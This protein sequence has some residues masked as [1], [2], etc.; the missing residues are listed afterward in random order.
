MIDFEKLDKHK[1]Y[2]GLQYGTSLI[3]KQIRRFSKDYAPDSKEIPTHVLAF[4]YRLGEWWIYESH[5]DGNK[6]LGVPAGVRRYKLS[7]WLEIEKNTQNQFKAVPFDFDFKTLEHYIGQ[8]YGVGDIRSL[9]KA[10]IFH[11]N[12]KQ[13]DRK[14]L[15]CSEYLALCAPCV[16]EFYNLPAYC[17]TPAHFQDY[18]EKNPREDGIDYK[19]ECKKRKKHAKSEEGAAKSE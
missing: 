4:V 19:P 16:A 9:L 14:G 1:T 8:P 5:S 18:I 15:I 12:G 10:A 6:D 11:S 2:L 17:I 13:K 3:A 7:V